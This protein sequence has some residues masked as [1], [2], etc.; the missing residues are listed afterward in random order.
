MNQR[1]KKRR[2][3]SQRGAT[4]STQLSSRREIVELLL[5][6]GKPL[7]LE[8]IARKL[9]LSDQQTHSGL[10]GRL[11]AMSQDGQIILGRRGRYG[12][13]QKMDLVAGRVIGHR[14]GFGFVTS[15][16]QQDDL[17]LSPREMR[18]VFHG[19]RVLAATIKV[20]RRGRLEGSIVEVLE[21]AHETIVG[22]YQ[23]D[24]DAHFVIPEDRRLSQDVLLTGA[25]SITVDDGDIVVVRITRQPQ[26]RRPATGEI[27]KVLGGDLTTELEIELV[28]R[29]YDIPFEWGPALE[30]QVSQL[31][32][33]VDNKTIKNRADLRE[34]ALITIDGADARDF[35][36]AVY[37][38]RIDHGWRVAVAIADVAHYVTPEGAIDEE[39]RNRGTSVYFPDRVVPMLPEALSN[40]LCSLRPAVDRLALV[41]WIDFATTG[42][43][44]NYR[45]EHAVIHS[46]ARLTYDQAFAFIDQGA[47]LPVDQRWQQQVEQ[48]LHCLAELHVAQAA[49]KKSRGALAFETKTVQLQVMDDGE[50][51]V[52]PGQ[53]RN[54]AHL[55]IE[56]CMVAANRCAAEFLE[57]QEIPTL[58]RGHDQPDSEKIVALRKQL[59]S[60]QLSLPGAE[61][62]SAGEMSSL[63]EIAH[64]RPDAQMIQMMVLRSLKQANY[65][66]ALRGH[67]G[68]GL[69]HYAHFTSPI[70]RYP[71]L[72]VHRAIGHCLQRKNKTQYRYS[73]EQMV[74]LG[75]ICSSAE[76][77]AD[78]AT[79]DLEAA[80]KCRYISG[81]IGEEFDGIVTGVTAFGLFI[82]LDD[83]LIDGLVHISS[84]RNDY[85]HYDPLLQRLTAERGGEVFCLGDRARVQVA[86]VSAEDRKIDFELINHQG[87]K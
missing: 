40:G 87:A 21:R 44:N 67:Y 36:D 5:L 28:L 81:H 11:A 30:D 24:Q 32:V 56:E 45:F 10:G 62:P 66:P 46:H 33:E 71:D 9:R 39:A 52:A 19:D 70:R 77:R 78:E 38:Q 84:L 64:Q 25:P 31:P 26:R 34:L 22:R 74:E 48:N 50:I 27:E 47:S 51:N 57:H 76:R 29:K 1:E 65:S 16:E 41:C 23:R 12:L 55:I 82:A 80:Y 7:T 18:K 83:L 73:L 68:M 75:E 86:R 59:G 13:A 6:S 8:E 69:E 20:D 53:P 54:Q 15:D 60:L 49:A 35:D 17:Y 79:R 72:L 85:Y 61:V 63:L 14:D 42:V 4:Q 43:I 2:N 3:S 58:H 37:C